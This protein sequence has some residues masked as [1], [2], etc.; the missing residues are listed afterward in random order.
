MRAPLRGLLLTLAAAL[1]LLAA[2]LW[3]VAGPGAPGGATGEVGPTGVRLIR[4]R[5]HAWGFRPGV[6]R[7]APGDIVRFVVT[8]DDIKHGFAIA[9]LDINLLL[10][11]D[12]EVRSPTRTITLP[13]GVYT[14]QC[15]AFCGMGHATM[16]A[17]LVVGTPAARHA[18][19][20]WAAV[21][22][23]LGIVAAVLATG[24]G[25]GARGRVRS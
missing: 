7:V 20:P 23:A 12:Q 2:A 17:R 24:A 15:S 4:I 11:P 9:E 19:A 14:I 22:A 8:S 10:G 16:K 13:E 25:R 1:P 5:A 18:V 3:L 6:V 21:V